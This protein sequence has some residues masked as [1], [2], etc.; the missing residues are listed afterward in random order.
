MKNLNLQSKVIFT[1]FREDVPEILNAMDIF[2]LP[3]LKEG[4]SRSIIEAM[5]A[6]KP[7]IATSVGGNSEAD[8][9]GVTGFIIPPN[10][11]QSLAERMIELL[12]DRNKMQN[13]GKKGRKRVEENFTAENYVENIEKIYNEILK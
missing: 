13:M 8:V 6:G 1:G 4:F 7:V 11:P 5:A 12:D 10:T 3:S 9:D 2:V